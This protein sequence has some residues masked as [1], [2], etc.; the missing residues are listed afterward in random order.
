MGTELEDE[1]ILQYYS[2]EPKE[3]ICCVIKLRGCWKNG[4][5]EKWNKNK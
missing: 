1:K 5:M 2:I 4:K 3:T